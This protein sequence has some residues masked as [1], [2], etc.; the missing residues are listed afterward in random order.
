M[1]RNYGTAIGPN[2]GTIITGTG[3]PLMVTTTMP[4]NPPAYDYFNEPTV[5]AQIDHFKTLPMG[6]RGHPTVMS[7]SGAILTPSGY[8]NQMSIAH[9]YAHPHQTLQ[10]RQASPVDC[11]AMPMGN[12]PVMVPAVTSTQLKQSPSSYQANVGH[13]HGQHATVTAA[14]ATSPFSR[15]IVTVRTPLLYTQQESCV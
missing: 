1:P 9:T 2:Q 11:M 7:P 13:P 3:D 5:Y 15:E 8:Q 10:L 4:K 6:N 12:G 14:T